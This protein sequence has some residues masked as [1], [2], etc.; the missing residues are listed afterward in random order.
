MFSSGH[1]SGILILI[2]LIVLLQIIILNF[3]SIQKYFVPKSVK[4]KQETTQLQAKIDSLKRN[5]LQNKF[6]IKPFNPNFI[7][8]YKGYMLGMSVTEINNL[9]TF[10]KQNKY[11]N[12]A[13][14]FQQITLVSDS[15]LN[16]IAPYFKFPNWVTKQ[17]SKNNFVSSS[18]EKIKSKEIILKDINLATKE[19]LMQISGIGNKISDIILQDRIKFGAFATLEQ[20]QYVWGINFNPE[21]YLN[22][23]KYFYVEANSLALK[24]IKINEASMNEIKQFPYFNFAIAKEIVTYRSMNGKIKNVTDLTKIK[25]FPI[26]KM[27][28]IV[29]YLEF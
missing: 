12:S 2:T 29:L 8:D 24:K 3:N 19:D 13:Q 27:D 7:T 28:I 15:L 25:A 21:T 22:I 4:S 1:R 20:L 9:H 16:T 5:T 6:E 26:E 23:Q 18:K 10:R 11:V 14:E 17:K